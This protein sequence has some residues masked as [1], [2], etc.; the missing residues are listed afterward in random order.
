MAVMIVVAPAAVDVSVAIRVNLQLR[1]VP[2]SSGDEAQGAHDIGMPRVVCV[3]T[4][5][6]QVMLDAAI[7]NG[8]PDTGAVKTHPK[9]K[10]GIHG[11]GRQVKHRSDRTIDRDV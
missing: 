10:L 6:L 11:R 9:G 4:Q 1:Y 7:E 2:V 8:D 3:C 5:G